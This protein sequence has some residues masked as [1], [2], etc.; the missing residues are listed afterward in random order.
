M[1]W[2]TAGYSGSAAKWLDA[3][4]Q[5]ADTKDTVRYRRD[6]CEIQAGCPKNTRQGRASLRHRTSSFIVAAMA[7]SLATFQSF[8]FTH[9]HVVYVHRRFIYITRAHAHTRTGGSYPKVY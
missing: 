7:A 8:S 4:I 5:R 1:Q 2:D 3:G 6:T 9:T